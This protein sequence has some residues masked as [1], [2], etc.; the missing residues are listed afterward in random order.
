MAW[1]GGKCQKG[2]GSGVHSRTGRGCLF[3]ELSY[4]S[5][6]ARGES[7]CRNGGG[8]G[9]RP[10]VREFSLFT[11]IRIPPWSFAKA[12]DRSAE[13]WELAAG[14]HLWISADTQSDVFW[15]RQQRQR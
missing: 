10:P 4:V 7:P 6:I 5:K 9:S 15:W 11:G 12:A 3:A 13:Q 14:L 8:S 2:S 1:G